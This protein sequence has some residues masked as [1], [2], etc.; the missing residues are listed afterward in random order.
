[1]RAVYMVAIISQRVMAQKMLLTR[2][3]SQS[4]SVN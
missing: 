2:I 1:M 4:N 3:V